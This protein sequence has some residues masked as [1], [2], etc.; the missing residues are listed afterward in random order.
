MSKK[1]E[2]SMPLGGTPLSSTS[3]MSRWLMLKKSG[4]WS[5]TLLVRSRPLNIPSVSGSFEWR[6]RANAN[7]NALRGPPPVGASGAGEAAGG[8]GLG[9]AGGG[10]GAGWGARLPGGGEGVLGGRGGGGGG[11][12]PRNAPS[13]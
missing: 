11:G 2:R 8:G 7:P 5:L 4:N 3:V 12:G 13:S 9:K 10:G 6:F 1:P